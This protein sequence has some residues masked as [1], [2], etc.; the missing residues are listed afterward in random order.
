LDWKN[1]AVELI[2]EPGFS[3][4]DPGPLHGPIIKFLARRDCRL[5]LLIETEAG[6]D[7]TSNAQEI[8]PGTVRENF[9][10]VELENEA[11]AKATLT[12]LSRLRSNESAIQVRQISRIQ[13]LNISLPAV[14]TPA[15]AIE[16]VDNLPT[17]HSWPHHVEIIDGPTTGISFAKE[18]IAVVDPKADHL[19]FGQA[20]IIEVEGHKLGICA[21][22]PSDDFPTKKYGCIIYEG[23]PDE[24]TRKKFRTAL[25]FAF[26]VYLVE[27][28]HTILDIDCRVVSATAKTAYALGHKALELTPMPLI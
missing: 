23:A 8:T 6:E 12:G 7:A 28:G 15:Y 22:T 26:G 9:D 27:T 17:G 20:V 1:Q 14:G 18:L 3:V 13:E 2:N 4:T 5:T 19:G 21:P 25:S 10:K 24:L 16:W 11:G